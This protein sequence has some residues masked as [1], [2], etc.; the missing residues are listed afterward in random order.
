MGE[1]IFF[2]QY[3]NMGKFSNTGGA[4]ALWTDH[5]NQINCSSH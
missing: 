4:K 5:G 3:R 2:L 1:I